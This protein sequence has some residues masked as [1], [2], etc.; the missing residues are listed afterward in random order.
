[1]SPL[2]RGLKRVCMCV[3]KW[4]RNHEKEEEYSG[5]GRGGRKGDRGRMT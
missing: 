4:K 5:M 1:M 3:M 2:T